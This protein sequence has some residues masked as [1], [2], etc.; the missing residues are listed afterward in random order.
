MKVIALLILTC[1]LLIAGL[2]AGVLHGEHRMCDQYR[3]V[4]PNT[5]F[6]VRNGVCSAEGLNGEWFSMH[7][8]K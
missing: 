8:I 4:F 5:H 7:G 3:E 2:A 6:E 1:A